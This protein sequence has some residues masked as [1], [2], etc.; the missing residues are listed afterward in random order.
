MKRAIGP[1]RQ[2]RK[3]LAQ[4]RAGRADQLAQAGYGNNGLVV[5][6]AQLGLSIGISDDVSLGDARAPLERFR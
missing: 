1:N 2:V 3:P 6:Q 4:P 5:V